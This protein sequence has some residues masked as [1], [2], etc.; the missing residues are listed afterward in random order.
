MIVLGLVLALGVG[1]ALAVQAEV[2]KPGACID[3]DLCAEKTRYGI[4]AFKR[5]K[6]SQAK[7]FFREAVQADPASLRA[8]SYYDLCVMYDVADQVKTTGRVK[9]SDAP[10]PGTGPDAVGAKSA[11][12]PAPAPEAPAVPA[13]IPAIP[14]DEGC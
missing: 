5:N 2:E 11:G 13:G 14:E 12:E 10:I 4:E 3:K 6:F 9:Y 7:A 8:W 1:I